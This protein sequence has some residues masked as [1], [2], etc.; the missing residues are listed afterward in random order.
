MDASP[1]VKIVMS[2][3][4]VASLLSWTLIM[5]K[6][7]KLSGL[8]RS[9][10]KFEEQF[11]NGVS[12]NTLYEDLAQRP[13]RRGL[14][15]IFFDGFHEYKRA[16][17]TDPGIRLSV[18]D[19][20]QRAMRVAASKEVDDLEQNLAFLA[21]VG[22]TSPYV[23]LFGTVWG[24]SV[25]FEQMA[26]QGSANLSE[27]APGISSALLTT[28]VGLIVAMPSAYGCNKLNEKIRFLSIQMENFIEKFATRLQQSFLYE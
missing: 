25:S 15:R 7:S 24:I 13:E 26:I 9:V 12:L 18:T 3:L 17:N 4:V 22:S 8:Q 2:M 1:V 6:A 5:S 20:V 23:G 10:N 16:L 19:S 14:E 27:A 21:T 28:I 11:W